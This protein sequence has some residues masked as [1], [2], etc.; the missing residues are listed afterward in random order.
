MSTTAVSESAIGGVTNVSKVTP[1]AVNIEKSPAPLNLQASVKVGSSNPSLLDG[2]T[3]SIGPVAVQH[4]VTTSAVAVASGGGSPVAG[5][6]I[7]GSLPL[8]MD[9]DALHK[10]G[11]HRETS[12]V[13]RKFPPTLQAPFGINEER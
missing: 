4:G 12:G 5:I 9:N 8:A 7:G 2:S 6:T 1:I 13:K 10:S 11:S 3:S